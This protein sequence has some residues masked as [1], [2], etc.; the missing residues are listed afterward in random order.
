M[1]VNTEAYHAIKEELQSKNV[2]L[3]AVSKTKPNKDIEAL[4]A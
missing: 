2:Q 4:Y 3:V 1:P